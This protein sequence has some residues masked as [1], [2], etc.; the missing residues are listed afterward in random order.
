MTQSMHQCYR[1]WF[2]FTRSNLFCHISDTP[3][4]FVFAVGNAT[5]SMTSH[6]KS[7]ETTIHWYIN[8][9]RN[10]A[11][12]LIWQIIYFM[13]HFM[14]RCLKL[15][16][17][18]WSHDIWS[19]VFITCTLYQDNILSRELESLQKWHLKFHLIPFMLLS[20]KH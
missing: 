19:Y 18:N 5:R 3:R 2:Q 14:V 10:I 20:N 7:G 12:Q 15:V 9:T 16:L 17:F 8:V 4:V 11:V 6:V 1:K 13:L